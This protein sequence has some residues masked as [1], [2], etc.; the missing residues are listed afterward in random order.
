MVEILKFSKKFKKIK[1]LRRKKS[2]STS[3][4]SS[5]E[6]INDFLKKQKNYDYICLLQPTSPLRTNKDIDSSIEKI[7][8]KNCTSL[9]SISKRV[10]G[11]LKS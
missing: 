1:T 2:L 5:Y 9:I 7:V 6:V 10:N 3:N 8:E 11:N 4:I